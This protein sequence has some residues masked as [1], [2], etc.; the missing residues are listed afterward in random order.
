M[1][2]RDDGVTPVLVDFEALA[3]PLRS[4]TPLM[5]DTSGSDAA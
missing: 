3:D 5:V 4:L 1:S 2:G